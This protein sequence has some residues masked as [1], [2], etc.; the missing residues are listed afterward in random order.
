MPATPGSPAAPVATAV[1]AGGA[2]TAVTAEAAPAGAAS[3]A[4]AA[5]AGAAGAAAADPRPLGRPVPSGAGRRLSSAGPGHRGAR[6]RVLY[7]LH[8]RSAARVRIPRVHPH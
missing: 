3:E 4:G 2:A 6:E 5:T 7:Q 1:T 8:Q